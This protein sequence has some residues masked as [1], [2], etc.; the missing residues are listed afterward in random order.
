MQLLRGAL[1]REPLL[2]VSPWFERRREQYQDA[3]LELSYSGNWNEWIGF[4]AEGVA[5]SAA[6][7]Q[8]KVERL[9][10]LQEKLRIRVQDAG[11]PGVAVRLAADLVG[12]PHVSRTDVRTRYALSGQG[13][14]NAIKV[15]V[16]LGI[17]TPAL[18]APG[19]AQTYVALDVVKIVAT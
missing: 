14:I 13:A 10:E 6:E 16:E 2:V 8:L 1:I 4:F 11:K 18:R 15:L 17:L 9:V 3:L 5:V 19:G 7:S 12:M